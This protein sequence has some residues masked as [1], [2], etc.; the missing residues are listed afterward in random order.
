MQ[1]QNQN[2]TNRAVTRK[3]YFVEEE[4][5]ESEEMVEGAGW[6]ER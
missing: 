1:I 6:R 2:Q 4:E 5:E 3:P